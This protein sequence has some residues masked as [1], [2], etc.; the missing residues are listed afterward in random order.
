MSLLL[1]LVF[2]VLLSEYGSDISSGHPF[3]WYFLFR[4]HGHSLFCSLLINF[5]KI[6]IL[7]HVDPHLR[8]LSVHRSTLVLDHFISLINLF[9]HQLLITLAY[10]FKLVDEI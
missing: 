1:L 3:E 6:I 7:V 2:L 5:L 4:E 8:F 10:K 9:G